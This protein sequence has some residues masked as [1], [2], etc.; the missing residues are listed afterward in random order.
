MR[1]ITLFLFVISTTLFS[2]DFTESTY[3][4]CNPPKN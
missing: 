3:V 1:Q 2:Q 4:A